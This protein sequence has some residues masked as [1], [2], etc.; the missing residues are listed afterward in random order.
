MCDTSISAKNLQIC[1]DLGTTT[2]YNEETS[3]SLYER[4]IQHLNDANDDGNQ[5]HMKIHTHD[6]HGRGDP[7]KSFIIKEKTPH[8]TALRWRIKTLS[9]GL[10]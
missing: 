4:A 1:K 3:N 7:V 10:L 6:A 8:Q 9:K 5:S 2:A